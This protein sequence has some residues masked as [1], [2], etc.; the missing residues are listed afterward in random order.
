[1]TQVGH[2]FRRVRGSRPLLPAVRGAL[3]RPPPA[4]RDRHPLARARLPPG[5]VQRVEPRVAL[6]NKDAAAFGPLLIRFCVL[7]GLYI[8]G[9]VYKLYYTQMLEMRW[10]TWLTGRFLG[11][12]LDNRAYYRLEVEDQR[13]TDNSDQRIADDL[14]IFTTNT[15]ASHSAFSLPP[16]RSFP[17]SPFSGP[18]PERSP[19]RSARPRSPSPA[20]WSGSRSSTRS[21]A[22]S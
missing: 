14:Q 8:L 20:T 2:F 3:A 4:R 17:S 1:M 6:Q 12:W 10:R 9:A 18:S 11:R 7:A 13:R 22:A 15:L 16:S 21:S 5:P 19:S